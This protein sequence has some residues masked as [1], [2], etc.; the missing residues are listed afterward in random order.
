MYQPK[1]KIFADGADLNS[2]RQAEK[3]PLI[4]G[5]TTNPTLMKKSGITNY[6][7]FA[8]KMLSVTGNLPVSFEVFA[9]EFNEMEKQALKIQSWGNNV[10]VK[11][12]VTN[13]RGES[14][15]PL[16]KSLVD[17]NVRINVTALFTFEQ[18][19]ELKKHLNPKV[20]S[21]VSVFAGRI[22][23]AGIDPNP[24]MKHICTLFKEMEKVE[25]LWAS[26]RQS[27]NIIE[28]EH[29]G[30]DIITVSEDLLKKVS[31]FGKNLDQFSLETVKMFYEDAKVA[32]YSI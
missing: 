27:L 28:A 13:T 6:T 18:C 5:F 23:D 3:N 15:Y 16:I 29:C 11:I 12:P 19:E 17:R 22:A 30:C 1:I 21:I 26:P 8:K 10:Y 4:K 7:S 14:S 32:G 31:S 24:I 9:D 2:I 20:P 25:V